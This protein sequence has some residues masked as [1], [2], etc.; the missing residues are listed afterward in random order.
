MKKPLACLP[1]CGVLLL[2]VLVVLVPVTLFPVCEADHLGW[3]T[4]YQPVMRCF[5]YGQAEIL[6]GIC[7]GVAGVALLLRPSRDTAFAVGFV[8]LALG[9]A[10]VL[11]SLNAVIGSVCGHAQSRCQIGTKPATRLAGGL[12]CLMGVCLLLWS[13]RKPR[14]S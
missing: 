11:V 9:A 10:I 14:S 5:W 3:V 6:L 13:L 4:D 7:V 8:L 2:G 12:T 1:G